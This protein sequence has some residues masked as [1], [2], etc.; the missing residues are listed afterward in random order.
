VAALRLVSWRW[1]R[2]PAL[3]PAL[4]AP[5]LAIFREIA[6][7]PALA[8][9][10]YPLIEQCLFPDRSQPDNGSAHPLERMGPPRPLTAKH[11]P[12]FSPSVTPRS[13]YCSTFTERVAQK[14]SWR[15]TYTPFLD[16]KVARISLGKRRGYESRP[17]SSVED[18]DI[19]VTT[20]GTWDGRFCGV[21]TV[22][23][24]TDGRQLFPF[25][26]APD[27]GPFDTIDAARAAAQAYGENLVAAD[28]A[29]PER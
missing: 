15:S 3:A 26:G 6:S 8:V 18:F 22:V 24:K 2:D 1:S 7:W 16:F 10:L 23:R 19:H 14:A 11:R 27:I 13:A 25:P 5:C 4:I 21:L 12:S 20:R 17:A 29:K 9:A 28:L